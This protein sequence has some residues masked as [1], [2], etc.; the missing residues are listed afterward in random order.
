[1]KL[2]HDRETLA[3]IFTARVSLCKRT[4]DEAADE[5]RAERLRCIA[6]VK[7]NKT[8]EGS[9]LWFADEFDLAPD[10]VRKAIAK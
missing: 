8:G 5:A 9:F 7:S 3:A 1:M 6:W 10:A 2:D 4:A